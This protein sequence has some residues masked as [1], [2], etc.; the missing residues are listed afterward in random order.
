MPQLVAAPNRSFPRA[1][2]IRPAFETCHSPSKK[3]RN[4]SCKTHPATCWVPFASC[5]TTRPHA[6]RAALPPARPGTPLAS[7]APR[8]GRHLTS[9]R[10]MDRRAIDGRNGAGPRPAS[11]NPPP[12]PANFG[13]PKRCVSNRDIVRAP[14]PPAQRAS[15]TRQL[16]RP[17]KKVGAD[18]PHTSCY[19]P[20]H[21]P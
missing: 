18:P 19:A 8:R 16:G 5:N 21:E 3:I 14:A 20:W 4:A 1:G 13:G 17:K 7:G 15:N 6:G 12:A 2:S 10:K 9:L 11:H